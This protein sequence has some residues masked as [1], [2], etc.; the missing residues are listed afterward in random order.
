[1][2]AIDELTGALIG[3]SNAA[4]RATD[5]VTDETDDIVIGALAACSGN[6]ADDS[7]L[8]A[9]AQRAHE[10]SAR[11]AKESD[12][13]VPADHDMNRLNDEDPL[14]RALKMLILQ[15]IRDAAGPTLRARNVELSNP[16]VNAFFR[17]ALFTIGEV[18][19]DAT[20][21]ISLAMSVGEVNWYVCEALGKHENAQAQID[22][23][24]QAL[25]A[26]MK[27]KSISHAFF[28]GGGNGS[29]AAY[30]YYDQ[31]AK[32]APADSVFLGY[33]SICDRFDALDLG[34]VGEKPR[35]TKMG[36]RHALYNAVQI[37]IALANEFNQSVN[38]LPMS[39]LVSQHNEEGVA[40]M[41]TLMWI[42][43][44][45]VSFGGQDEGKVS[46]TVLNLYKQ[47]NKLRVAT[48][49]AEAD[50]KGLLER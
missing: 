11:L 23:A 3:L 28:V 17:A 25:I 35:F 37:S 44:E 6:V 9:F 12:N 1:M 36:S 40:S 43:I 33:G 21:L 45:N 5:Y 31:F 19:K 41:L 14:S 7:V 27:D 29:D 18:G 22:E 50:L 48:N 2:N 4:G 8:R 30:D 38:D 10:E 49:D 15:G 34:S 20:S 13:A 42:G 16:E 46:P 32:A 26:G 39:F 24:A 47:V